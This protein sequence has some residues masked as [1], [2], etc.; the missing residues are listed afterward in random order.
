MLYSAQA[1]GRTVPPI[2]P[3]IYSPFSQ[4]AYRQPANSWLNSYPNPF[5][6]IVKSAA[7][8]IAGFLSST[9]AVQSSAK[10]LLQLMTSSLQER[11][12]SSS[13]P[14]AVKASAKNG[15]AF[16]K[17][18]IKVHSVAESQVNGGID[19]KK[20]NLTSMQNGANRFKIAFGD[21]AT[22]ITAHISATDTNEQAL[23]KLR[24]A[25]NDAK[26]GVTASVAVDSETGNARLVLKGDRTG[27][28]QAYAVEDEAGNAAASTGMSNVTSAAA[29][30]SY[31]V[32]GGEIRTSQTNAVELEK[33]KVT[34][35]LVKSSA[36]AIDIE[37]RPDAKKAVEQ[38]GELISSY[39][40]M[41]DKLNEA[42]KYISPA[43][44]AS[45]DKA[46][47]SYSNEA[48]GIRQNADGT[49]RLD[50]AAFEK[51][52]NANF[53]QASKSIGGRGGLADRLLKRRN[54][55]TMPPP[56]A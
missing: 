23:Y 3:F 40:A 6:R 22:S 56:A 13:N 24:N 34:A 14:E 52:L 17:Y 51:S 45:L 36:D 44:K 10:S 48:I 25:I 54:A 7:K 37:V 15:A 19:L 11:V 20:D 29:N 41:R 28:E 26:A 2:S 16:N 55:S 21:K 18:Q 38:V 49:L 12:A 27:T 8:D 5:E 47:S 31:T 35:T 1:V 30:A 33:G 9:Q 42:G 43:V 32:N 39:N 50:E 46:A 53:G 4:S